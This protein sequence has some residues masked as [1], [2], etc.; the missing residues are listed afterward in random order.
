MLQAVCQFRIDDEHQSHR[1]IGWA[2]RSCFEMGLHRSEV[3]SKIAQTEED[4]IW[5]VR[6][7]WTVYILDKRWSF[8]T[9]IPFA[10]QDVDIDPDLPEPVSTSALLCCGCKLNY[11]GIG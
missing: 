10:M 5:I 8:G 7:F 9:G 4:S 11:I 3:L 1:I 6:L 2:A